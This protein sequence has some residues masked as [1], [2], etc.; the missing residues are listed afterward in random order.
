M[1]EPTHHE[2]GVAAVIGTFMP[3]SCKGGHEKPLATGIKV[4]SASRHTIVSKATD[5]LNTPSLPAG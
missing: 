2:V 1:T 3:M 4:S 5:I